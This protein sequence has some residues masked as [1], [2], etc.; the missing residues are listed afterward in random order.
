[1]NGLESERQLRVAA[2]HDISCLGRCSLTV[3]LPV[4]SAMGIE[5]NVIPTAILSSHTGE[6]TG[7][8][9]RDLTEDIY[10]IAQHWKSLG[11]HYDAMYT[12]YFGNIKQLEI[13]EKACDLLSDSNTLRFVDPVMADNGELYSHFDMAY[14]NEMKTFCRKA[15][16]IL[17]NITEACLLTDTPYVSGPYTEDD[18]HKLLLKLRTL[19]TNHTVLTGAHTKKGY[20]A[21]WMDNQSGQWDIVLSSYVEGCFYGAGDTLASVLLGSYLQ[22]GSMLEAVAVAVDFT[23]KAI[24]HTKEKEQDLKYG[25]LFEELLGELTQ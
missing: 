2:I 22:S 1:M 7:Y 11:R 6:F 24:I 25:L 15:H 9:F 19:G 3:A 17:P 20:G 5:T 13:V 8:T 18:L 16:V 23:H 12:G 21:A 4:L 14:V 10:P